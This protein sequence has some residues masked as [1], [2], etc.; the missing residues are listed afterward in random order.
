MSKRTNTPNLHDMFVLGGDMPAARWRELFSRRAF[1]DKARRLVW[2]ADGARFMPDDGFVPEG[3]VSLAHPVEL[4]APEILRWRKL[5]AERG[6]EQPFRQMGEPVVLKQGKLPGETRQVRSASEEFLMLD[7][8][9]DYNLTLSAMP[10]LEKEG[11]RFITRQQWVEASGEFEE[12]RVVNI[13]TPAGILY[14]C[15]PLQRIEKLSN[16]PNSRLELNM[17]YPFEGVRLRTLNHVAATLEHYLLDE[18][19]A[20]DDIEKLRP[21]L[22]GMAVAELKRLL[23]CCPAGS[24]TARL[25]NKLIKHEEAVGS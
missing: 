17:F 9:K 25:L 15:K 8:F 23:G 20:R 11:F 5:L 10:A 4:D 12:I 21:N 19:A 18:M 1:A 3:L 16:R 24:E 22:P 13:V 14:N 2:Q 6:I 7:H